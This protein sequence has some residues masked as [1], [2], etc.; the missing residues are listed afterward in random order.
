M[1]IYA[2]TYIYTDISHILGDLHKK[3]F[4]S[5]RDAQLLTRHGYPTKQ[6]AAGIKGSPQS[7]QLSCPKRRS[8]RTLGTALNRVCY[9]GCLKGGS[10]GSAGTGIEAVVVLTLI[11]LK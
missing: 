1:C 8:W 4:N 7:E 5:T 6:H 9:F 10:K 3:S 11:L 2:Y